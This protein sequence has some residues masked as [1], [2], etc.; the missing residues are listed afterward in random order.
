MNWMWQ[1]K[2]K[3]DFVAVRVDKKTGVLYDEVKRLIAYSVCPEEPIHK[4]RLFRVSLITLE[5]QGT[6]DST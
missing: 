3:C 2:E 4:E 6:Q 5:Q 1:G